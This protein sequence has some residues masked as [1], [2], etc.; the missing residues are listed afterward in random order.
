MGYLGSHLEDYWPHQLVEEAI[1]QLTS[2]EVYG[3]EYKDEL[4]N[5][6]K[7]NV[8]ILNELLQEKK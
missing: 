1:R 4:L 2:G 8:K 3:S 6:L 7:T 5:E